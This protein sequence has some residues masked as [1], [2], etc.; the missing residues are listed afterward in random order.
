MHNFSFILL[1]IAIIIFISLI[2]LFFFIYEQESK[3]IKSSMSLKKNKANIKSSLK[4]TLTK[5][6][7]QELLDNTKTIVRKYS[8][9]SAEAIRKWIHED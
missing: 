3:G 1:L 7:K 9:Q 8:K 4:T 6:E 2:V 5:E